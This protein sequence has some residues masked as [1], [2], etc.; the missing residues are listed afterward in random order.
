MDWSYTICQNVEKLMVQ[1][2][3]DSP[4]RERP[5]Y[6]GRKNRTSGA[7]KRTLVPYPVRYRNTQPPDQTPDDGSGQEERRDTTF[8]NQEGVVRATAIT[9]CGFSWADG[10]WEQPR[11]CRQAS[12]V[13]VDDGN[14]LLHCYSVQFTTFFYDCLLSQ[15]AL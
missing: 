7:S 6:N 15:A 4:T 1:G 9:A 14:T 2:E 5:E 8:C 13:C 11:V 10:R 3:E 12:A